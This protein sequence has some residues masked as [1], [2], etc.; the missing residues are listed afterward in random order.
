MESPAVPLRAYFRPDRCSGW[1]LEMQEPH[2]NYIGPERYVIMNTTTKLGGT[3]ILPRPLILDPPPPHVRIYS[4]FSRSTLGGRLKKSQPIMNAKKPT[5]LK[6][7]ICARPQSPNVPQRAISF[8]IHPYL[9]FIRVPK[10][11]SGQ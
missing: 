5:R 10:A 2:T 1:N 8:A 7:R 4:F 11:L 3:Y 9:C 6:S